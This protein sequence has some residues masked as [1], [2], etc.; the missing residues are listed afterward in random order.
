MITMTG[1]T[2]HQGY[3]EKS[4]YFIDR[5]SLMHASQEKVS[6]TEQKLTANNRK[7]A[8]YLST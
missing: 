3:T 4:N 8:A 5:V 6:I 1:I 2:K 7:Y